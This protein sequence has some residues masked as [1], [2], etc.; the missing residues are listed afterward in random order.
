M[1]GSGHGPGAFPPS[2]YGG[3]PPPPLPP[4]LP[5]P[6]PFPGPGAVLA[7]ALRALFRTWRPLLT[8]LLLA[9][10]A[11][12]VAITAVG[13]SMYVLRGAPDMS[14][15]DLSDVTD[16]ALVVFLPI[17]LGFYLMQGAVSALAATLAQQHAS[18]A[19]VTVGGLVRA[20]A[21][22]VPGTVG[23]YLLTLF[24]L[25]LILTMCLAP[26]AAWPWVLFLLAPSVRA[27]EGGGALAALVRAGELVR[28]VWWRTFTP[29]ALAALVAFAVDV[30]VGFLPFQTVVEE[31]GEIDESVN[32]WGQAESVDESGEPVEPLTLSDFSALLG[33]ITGIVTGLVGLLMLQ[34]AFLHLVADQ[35]YQA[36]RSRRPVTSP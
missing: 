36:L 12:F 7:G 28:G 1:S 5:L 24:L 16:V 10:L 31:F 15:G 20:S 21:P 32:E 26:L 4:P 35:L 9:E 30:A 3:W 18:G 8:A 27:H 2:P 33:L 19:R 22:R 6:P 17:V 29:L 13:L 23:G 25:P 11:V 34:L 14:G